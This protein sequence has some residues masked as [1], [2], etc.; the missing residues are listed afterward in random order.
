[1]L[2]TNN[3][4]ASEATGLTSTSLITELEKV[5]TELEATATSGDVSKIASLD[6]IAPGSAFLA[7]MASALGL[8]E[9]ERG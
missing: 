1:M 2:D 8:T 6:T 7:G 9:G 5:A 3:K 4:Y